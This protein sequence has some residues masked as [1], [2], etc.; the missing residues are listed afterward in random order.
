VR[1]AYVVH[2]YH[3]GGGHSRY[4]AELATRF[5]ANGHEV[6]VLANRFEAE[7]HSAVRFHKVPALRLNPLATVLSFPLPA[8]CMIRGYDIVHA[9]GFCCWGANVVTTHICSQAWHEA[10][11]RVNGGM[12]L[13]HAV[14]N[15]IASSLEQQ[16]YRDTDVA[17]VIAIS[18]MVAVDIQRHYGC[19]LPTTVIYHGVDCDVFSPAV[20]TQDRSRSRVANGLPDDAF[21]FL[22]VGDLRKGALQCIR[23]AAD[24]PGC[25]VLFVSRS[26][27]ALYLKYAQELNVSERVHFSGPTS[28]I[29][30]M[31]AAADALVLP[32]PY[33]TFAMVVLEAMAAGLPVIVSQNAGAAE[34]VEDGKQG[35][36]L[37]DPADTTGLAWR[38]RC[39][40]DS[41]ALTRQMGVLARTTAE[42]HSWDAVA[43]QTMDVYRKVV[44][45][46]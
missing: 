42:K 2:D 36:I 15:T 40:T 27:P 21:V 7:P 8:T 38:M 43:Q 11:R 24:V 6:H 46:R 39:L 30:E 14:F 32:T 12:P 20:R 9:Q 33:D 19:V 4:V 17:H 41:P 28:R 10:I 25:H 34:L 16:L 35:L 13:R 44:R 31:Y 26:E 5:A 45:G 3:R 37:D 1:I 23:A 18:S 29:E 22:Y